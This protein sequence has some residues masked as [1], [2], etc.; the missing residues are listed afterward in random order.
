VSLSSSFLTE[1]GSF[2]LLLL[3]GGVGS[4]WLS[5][6]LGGS[7]SLRV[8][9]GI[10]KSNEAVLGFLESSEEEDSALAAA[11]AT[12]GVSVSLLGFFFLGILIL[13]AA[14]ADNGFSSSSEK[15]SSILSDES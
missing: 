5:L 4:W 10:L 9:R 11:T 7:L 15:P 8:L 12:T 13:S 1:T 2:L 6:L 3:E 14:T